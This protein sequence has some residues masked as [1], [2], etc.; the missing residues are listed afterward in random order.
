MQSE[1]FDAFRSIGVEEGKALRAAAAP[2]ERENDVRDL[3]SDVAILRS[4]VT[5]LKSDVAAL[6]SNVATNTAD[7]ATLKSDNIIMKWM[8]GFVLAFQV[9]I[10]VK[11]FIH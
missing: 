4:D 5:I 8:M 6:K 7:I 11:M 1:V 3:K 9:A 10:F 2:N